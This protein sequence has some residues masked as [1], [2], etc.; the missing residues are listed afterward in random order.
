MTPAE[1]WASAIS[2]VM[3]WTHLRDRAQAAWV[4]RIAKYAGRPLFHWLGA[5]ADPT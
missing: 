5:E 3:W 4:R 2:P 1:H